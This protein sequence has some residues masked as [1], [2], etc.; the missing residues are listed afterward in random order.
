MSN[1][2]LLTQREFSFFKPHPIMVDHIERC[3]SF[4]GVPKKDFRI[5]DWGCGRGVLVLWLRERGYDAVGVDINPKAFQNG[6]ALFASKGY[7][8]DGCLYAL[9][10][11]GSAPFPDAS[12]H[13]VIS[14]QA[15]EHIEDLE[16][17]SA[18][19]ARVTADGGAG[20]HIYPPH[21]RLVEAHL[22]MPFVHWLPKN[23]ARKWL[24]GFFVLAGVEPRWWPN[25]KVSWKE[26][27]RVYYKYSVGETF[28]RTPAAIRGVLAAQG[29]EMEFVDVGGGRRR[30]FMNFR[31]DVGLATTRPRRA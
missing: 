27:Q 2:D 8:V 21:L 12:F 17:A 11:C 18:E 31:G 19:W 24:I 10:P 25:Q 23:A 16:A 9:D 5:V 6:A 22:F 26:K 14:Y 7:P 29:L 1:N 15:L 20:F 30:W 3:R 28:Y 13:F 4:F